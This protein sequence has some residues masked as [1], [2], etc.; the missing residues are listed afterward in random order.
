LIPPH[1]TLVGFMAAGKSTVGPALATRVR[2]RYVDLDED[3]AATAGADIP[4]IFATKGEVAFRMLERE[5]LGRA[6][7][8]TAPL[9]LATGGGVVE[10]PE[11]RHVLRE[12]SLVLWLDVRMETVRA[13]CQAQG[14]VVRP[15][16]ARLG[17]DGLRDLLTRRRALY[18]EVAHFRFD[19]DAAAP[20]VLARRMAVAVR[21]YTTQER[22]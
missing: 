4:T 5:H 16:V 13:R 3:I 7:E 9:V 2:K 20:A 17:W 10:D 1:V 15:L 8:A 22:V 12:R 18:A 21:Q 11:N 6:L 14:A 19:C